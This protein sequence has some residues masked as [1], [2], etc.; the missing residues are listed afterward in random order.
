MSSSFAPLRSH[1]LIGPAGS[2]K[3]TFAT[4]LVQ[5]NPALVVV[6]T[7][8]IRQD[9]YGDATIQGLWAE[10]EQAVIVRVQAAIQSGRP[11]IYDATNIK[12]PWRMQLIEKFS[13][14][15]ATSWLAWYLKTPL[16]TCLYQNT[17]RDRQVP[18]QVIRRHFKELETFAPN[19]AEGFINVV[20]L[21]KTVQNQFVILP[22]LPEI[23]QE[24]ARLSTT[25]QRAN[26]Y[27]QQ[28]RHGYSRLKDFERLLFL[29]ALVLHHPGAGN[30]HETHPEQLHHL[31]GHTEFFLTAEEEIAALLSKLHHPLYADTAALTQ[32]LQWLRE[33]ALLTTDVQD[34]QQPYKKL[35]QPPFTGEADVRTAHSYGDWEAFERLLTTLR[36]ILYHPLGLEEGGALVALVQGLTKDGLHVHPDSVRRDI[37]EVLKPYDLLRGRMFKQGYY[38]GTAIFS[39]EELQNIHAVLYSQAQSLKNP[40]DQAIYE[41]YTQKMQQAQIG[42]AP[43]PVR[44]IANR[45]IVP[46]SSED[47]PSDSLYRNLE[48]LE[49]YITTGTLLHLSLKQ[50]VG[51]WPKDRKGLFSA[52]PLQIVFHNIAWYLGYEHK[53]DGLFRYGRLDRLF[54]AQPLPQPRGI[55]LQRRS[56][57]RI[58]TLLK[59][60]AFLFLGDDPRQQQ[61]FLNTKTRS[62]VQVVVELWFTKALSQFIQEGTKRFTQQKLDFNTGNTRFPCRLVAT[63]PIW[64]IEDIDLQRWILGYGDQVNVIQPQSLAEK[65]QHIIKSM[66]AL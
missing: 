57:K 40:L 16:E 8:D 30:L 59:G 41:Q 63:L 34:L 32:D 4:R 52:W 37:G 64:S 12:R 46:T 15:G 24:I 33:N 6:S 10:V 5:A 27:A 36:Y 45:I 2:G 43:Y 35:Q 1:F 17:Q 9:L 56:L 58:D 55:D 39:R 26:R 22:E 18:P 28:T 3:S 49:R 54:L 44:A 51:T 60:S 7:D 50:N 21:G 31:L 65:I 14:L 42:E 62:T 48:Q 20:T 11:V 53:E 38:A 66:R 19:P 61:L 47:L 23:Q 29:L 25:I 13:S